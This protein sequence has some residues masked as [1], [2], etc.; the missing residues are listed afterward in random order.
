LIVRL[1]ES[2]EQSPFGA[3]RKGVNPDHPRLDHENL[4]VYPCAL[5]VLRLALHVTRS[6]PRAESELRDQL[7]RAAMSVPLNIAEGA[8]KPSTADRARYHGIARGSAMEC[9]ALLDVCLVASAITEKEHGEGK[10]LLVRIVA[11][12]DGADGTLYVLAARPD[13]L[14]ALR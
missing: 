7:K 3:R 11:M 4:D 12:F 5:R 14:F 8:G 6:L 10:T 9:G 1:R 13:R 2:P